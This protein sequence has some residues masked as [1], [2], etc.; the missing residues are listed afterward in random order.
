MAMRASGAGLFRISRSLWGAGLLLSL[1]LLYLS[2]SLV[3]KSVEQSRTFI[4]NLEFS[5]QE[6]RYDAS[7]VGLLYNFSFDNRKDGRLWLNNF[8][9]RAWLGLGVNVHVM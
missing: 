3:P 8:S 1:L 7:Q 5:A 6:A 4:D 9:E 2:T